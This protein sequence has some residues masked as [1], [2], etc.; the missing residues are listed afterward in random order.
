MRPCE[1]LGKH[2]KTHP[3]RDACARAWVVYVLPTVLPYL[4]ASHDHATKFRSSFYDRF[5]LQLNIL[6]RLPAGFALGRGP[7]RLGRYYYI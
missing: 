3:Q 4:H 5:C 1:S 2:L 7:N 6:W